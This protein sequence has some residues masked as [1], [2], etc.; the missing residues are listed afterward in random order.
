[1]LEEN[2]TTLATSEKKLTV[3]ISLI[4][5][6]GTYTTTEEH[7]QED[8]DKYLE[9]V[10]FAV[11]SGEN[12]ELTY[13]SFRYTDSNGPAEVVVGASLLKRSIFDVRVVA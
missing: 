7:T 1:M 11:Q 9:T 2:S 3:V 10:K 4:T 5:P 8:Y 12:G 6:L 13:F